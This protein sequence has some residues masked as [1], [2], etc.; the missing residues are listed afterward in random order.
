M[1]GATGSTYTPVAADAGERLK[2]RVGFT[3]DAGHEE[4]LTS[5]ATDA[6]T[7]AP[8]PLTAAFEGMPA[9]HAGQGSF[10]FQVAFSDGINISYKTVRDASF[11]VTGGAVTRARRVDKR[12]DLWKITIEPASREAV[13]VWLPETTNCDAT[14]AIC[15]SGGQPRLPARWG[16]RWPMRGWKKAT[17]WRWRSWSRS[18]GWRAGGCRWTTP[19]RTAART[20]ATTTGRRAGR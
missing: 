8:E 10:A 2:V 7:A 13:T 14:G 17:A 16:S 4:S 19:R 5:A 12:R 20:R 11:T 1:G 15:T 3:D 6:V 9:E 18:A